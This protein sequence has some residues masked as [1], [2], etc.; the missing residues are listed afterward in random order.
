MSRADFPPMLGKNGAG[1]TP[2]THKLV[3]RRCSSTKRSPSSTSQAFQ[4]CSTLEGAAKAYCS[5][6]NTNNNKE[7]HHAVRQGKSSIWPGHG[8]K[9]A[10]VLDQIPTA[11]WR[12]PPIEFPQPDCRELFRECRGYKAGGSCCTKASTTAAG[13]SHR[14]PIRISTPGRPARGSQPSTCTATRVAV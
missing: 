2:V 7:R 11:V 3:E 10:L 14:H 5:D 6:N 12:Q 9:G 13:R 4:I 1:G 8:K